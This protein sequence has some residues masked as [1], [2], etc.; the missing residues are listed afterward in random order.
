MHYDATLTVAFAIVVGV[1]STVIAE[2]TII[3]ATPFLF[4]RRFIF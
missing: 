1:V 4:F 2:S 3:N